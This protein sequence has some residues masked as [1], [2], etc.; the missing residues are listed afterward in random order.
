MSSKVFKYLNLGIVLELLKSL[1]INLKLGKPRTPKT[2]GLV[3]Q[4]NSTLKIRLSKWKSETGRLDWSNGLPI[5]AISINNTI[6]SSTKYTPYQLVFNKKMNINFLDTNNIISDNQIDEIFMSD[7]ENNES[8]NSNIDANNALIDTSLN[9]NYEQN[10]S[11][12]NNQNGEV[13]INLGLA[14]EKMSKRYNNKNKINVFKIDQKVSL[15]IPKEDRAPTDEKRLLC[16]VISTPFDDKYQLCCQYGILKRLFS[17]KDIE[18]IS[19]NIDIGF[20]TE[21]SK[22]LGETTLSN[23]AKNNST[24][25]FMT[26]RCF[27]KEKCSGRCKCIKNKVQCSVYCHG[28]SEMI[29]ENDKGLH[30]R[31]EIG[32]KRRR[33]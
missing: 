28:N 30:T 24:A 21:L 22:L 19:Q 9:I 32:L 6:H 8:I 25:L 3:E 16:V 27:C 13:N 31:T 18:D 11:Q 5:V 29:C 10:I 1:N 12:M 2:Q 17:T 15:K 4:G 23:A 14:R 26:L 33:K 20:D 7:N